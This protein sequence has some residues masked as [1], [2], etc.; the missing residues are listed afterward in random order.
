MKKWAIIV[1]W[2]TALIV[3]PNLLGGADWQYYS[4]NEHFF[5][6]YDPAQVTRPEPEVVQVWT[7]WIATRE[8]KKQRTQEMTRMKV[9]KSLAERYE[10]TRVRM[11]IHCAARTYQIL[12]LGDYD[13]LQREIGNGSR[14]CV[15][16]EFTT[17]LPINK[18]S[19]EEDLHQ[20]L[21]R[22]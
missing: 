7:N 15:L 12:S 14:A 2:L 11:A 4:A 1:G 10:F 17:S 22:D 18:N 9:P 19:S 8:G 21:C 5:C 3:P 16:P 13:D 20:L 6:L